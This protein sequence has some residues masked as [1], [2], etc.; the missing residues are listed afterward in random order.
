MKIN[1]KKF[2]M[3][4]IHLIICIFMMSI[5]L[6]SNNLKHVS[7][8]TLGVLIYT[9][10]IYRLAG[11]K[12][13]SFGYIFTMCLM[14]F[15]F[16]Q[17][18]LFAL[19]IDMTQLEGYFNVFSM[20]SENTIIQA[21]RFASILILVTIGIT[22]I[23]NDSIKKANFDKTVNNINSIEKFLFFLF[24]GL[25]LFSNII[26]AV[27]VKTIGY[28][29]GYTFQNSFFYQLNQLILPVTIY[30][31]KRTQNKLESQK[32]IF[33]LAIINELIIILLVGNRG[34][35]VIR[36]LVMIIYYYNFVEKKS[37]SKK[38]KFKI[39]ISSLLIM[40]LMPFV[41]ATRTDLLSMN[42][43]DFLIKENPLVIFLSEFG[44]SLSTTCYAIDAFNGVITFNEN[45]MIS[46]VLAMLPMAGFFFPNIGENLKF[47]AE[48]NERFGIRGLG[49]SL[50]GEF[51]Y[52]FGDSFIGVIIFA[53]IYIIVLKFVNKEL[54]RR[55]E[56][57]IYRDIFMSQ[58]MFGMLIWV[59]GSLYDFSMSIKI[60]I[61]FIMILIILKSMVVKKIK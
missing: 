47:A 7:I 45:Q 59:R 28:A 30:S 48:L 44:S 10:F 32:M 31:L 6:I 3:I 33:A 8:F 36:I 1:A 53:I 38:Q 21:L 49:G 16:G 37:L 5:V 11:V 35:S 13:L 42:F 54:S 52:N 19:G 20:F 60:G 55:K 15:N 51:I 41:S 25:V 39:L 9:F 50:T 14:L 34:T 18:W 4:F 57:Q 56:F 12:V 2:N 22:I 46:C 40:L 27:N 61:Y 17:S 24:W 23:F 43:I 29:D 26:R 58:M